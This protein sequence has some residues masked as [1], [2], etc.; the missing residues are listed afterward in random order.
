MQYEKANEKISVT[1]M[2]TSSPSTIADYRKNSDIRKTRTIV[3]V[4]LGIQL[5]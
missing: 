4:L 3:L 1:A 5:V 2:E